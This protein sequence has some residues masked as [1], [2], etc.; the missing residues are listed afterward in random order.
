MN[1]FNRIIPTTVIDNFF[2][3]PDEIRKYALSLEFNSP[4][5]S[6]PGFRSE[7]IAFINPKLYEQINSRIL[8]L[9]F[10]Q[11]RDSLDISVESQFQIIPEKFEEGWAHQ[12]VDVSGRNIAGVIYLTPDAPLDCG[13]SIYRQKS[14]PDY[15]DLRL[16]NE[17][18]HKASIDDIEKYRKAR[19]RYNSN[20]EK[21]LEV[22]NVYNRLL[23]YDTLEFHK[24]SGF[25]G[26]LKENSRLTIV[27]FMTINPVG[28]SSF[29]G[30]RLRNIVLDNIN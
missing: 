17:Y 25:F 27:F 11:N 29:P 3:N 13:T 20:F 7:Q 23:M 9:F 24:E 10:D 5:G 26:S 8:S 14:E 16:R 12:D 19:D 2:D 18:Y 28:K 15:N 22:K 30:T 6:Y 21:T 4:R 1:N